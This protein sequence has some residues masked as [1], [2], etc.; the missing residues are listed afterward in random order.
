MK[1]TNPI[2]LFLSSVLLS[3][4][5]IGSVCNEQI[6]TGNP[7]KALK[8][9]EVRFNIT[10]DSNNK[11]KVLNS[12]SAHN[13]I[14]N[15]LIMPTNIVTSFKKST[16]KQYLSKNGTV[17]SNGTNGATFKANILSSLKNNNLNDFLALQGDI[18]PGDYINVFY[19][20]GVTSASN[21]YVV[22]TE[23]YGDSVQTVQAIN[24]LGSPI[25]RL[26][27]INSVRGSG[28]STY[29][30]TG[31]KV[32]VAQTAEPL[33]AS[34]YPLTSLLPRGQKIYGLKVTQKDN[35]N[36]ADG[37]AFIILD[38]NFLECTVVANN[39]DF[40]NNPLEIGELS[41]SIFAD[42]GNGTDK[43]NLGV[44]A[45]DSD[46]SNTISITNFDGLA[47]TTT[48]TTKG[49]LKIPEN[50][51][52]GIYKPTY[53]ICLEKDISYCDTAIISLIVNNKPIAVDDIDNTDQGLSMLVD[54]LANDYHF[55]TNET[56][57]LFS[58]KNSQNNL[59][60]LNGT[61]V[62]YT[63]NE[64]F[65][66]EDTFTYIVEDMKGNQ[67]EGLATI[68]VR[69]APD[70][71]IE[72]S[73]I[74]EGGFLRFNVSLTHAYRADM[75]IT[76]EIIDLTTD[77]LDYNGTA[78]NLY[79]DIQ[80]GELSKTYKLITTNDQKDE[81]NE[82]L[83]IKIKEVSTEIGDVSSEAVGKIIDDDT[84]PQAIEDFKLGYY[85]K[86]VI[87]DVLSNDIDGTADLDISKVRIVD[88]DVLVKNLIING[89]GE[90]KINETNGTISFTPEDKYVGDPGSIKY[91]ISDIAGNTDI[92]NVTLNYPPLAFDDE[93]ISKVN[94]SIVIN[95]L[96]NDKAT[97][98][99]ID[100]TNVKLID[101]NDK[102]VDTMYVEG[103]GT[104]NVDKTKGTVEFVPD[105][106][107]A[108]EVVAEYRISETNGEVSNI[109]KITIAYPQ[110]TDDILKNILGGKESSID[111]IEND[112]ENINPSSVKLV[113]AKDSGILIVSGE[114]KWRLNESVVSFTPEEGFFKNP[115]PIQYTAAY[116]NIY[117]EP[118]NISIMYTT[119]DMYARDDIGIIIEKEETVIKVLSNDSYGAYGS[120]KEKIKVTKPKHGRIIINDN[121]TA[122]DFSDDTLTYKTHKVDFIGTD[123]FSYTITDMRGDT[124][125]AKVILNV[126]KSVSQKEDSGEINKLLFLLL[127]PFLIIVIRRNKRN[128]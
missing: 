4:I 119:G 79:L 32:S 105:T 86:P 72:D 128:K 98:T 12:I 55:D 69:K 45:I 27:T 59:V 75:R 107:F 77:S 18:T 53:R 8:L 56:L 63:P 41:P 58:V 21:R 96:L 121:G 25:G 126:T 93:G 29:L 111:V 34:V 60:E 35:G 113:G 2:H 81:K 28:A 23:T 109:A 48:I 117:L 52:S 10:D 36:G 124:A 9:G 42:N 57:K 101:D 38:E 122:S 114:G 49:E 47:A 1:L 44:D 78:N 14:Y 127:L 19:P 116:K 120:G 84:S 104:F 102:L 95:V 33:Y 46:I 94:D 118:A 76:F 91:L 103:K 110:L 99:P 92:S 97:S 37:K 24:S 82:E 3:T 106:N 89:E 87:I 67:V 16:P 68:N 125:T 66:G 88:N 26:I 15:K 74:I 22:V 80:S 85:G 20:N 100:I 7:T 65:F 51:Q 39:D 30:S 70:V 61:K 115:T 64:G 13:I 11:A 17:I 71:L 5:L 62:L 50:T 31:I 108:G 73:S 54:V 112:G 40:K 123:T 83:K 6:P 43:S 90:W